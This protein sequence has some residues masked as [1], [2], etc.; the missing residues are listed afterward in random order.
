MALVHLSDFVELADSL[1][2][3][4]KHTMA[5]I[6]ATDLKVQSEPWAHG[7]GVLF[8]G[9]FWGLF[10]SRVCLAFS[11]DVLDACDRKQRRFFSTGATL[12]PEQRREHVEDIA[13][14]RPGPTPFPWLICAFW[15][16]G[17]RE[18]DRH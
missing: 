1:P 6:R 14:V 15:F 17:G 4:L 5:E 3:D 2:Q 8:G 10:L 9:C 11:A 12:R 16:G 7:K 18:R 13:N